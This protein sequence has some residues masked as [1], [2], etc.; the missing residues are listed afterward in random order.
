MPKYILGVDIGGTKCA[1]NLASVNSHVE[2]L[3]RMSFDTKAEL[4]FESVKD[5]LFQGARDILD[6]N[7]IAYNERQMEKNL[8]AI[9][10]SCG[11]PLDCREGLILSPPHLPGWDRI[12]LKKMMTEAFGVPVFVQNDANACALVEWKMG[13]GRGAQNMVFIT[14]GT[15]FGAGIIAEN[16]LI[17]GVRGFA[18]E[19]GHVRLE[20]EGPLVFGKTGT[21]E[22]FCS[23]AGIGHLAM[24]RT[25]RWLAQGHEPAW[26]KDGL[27]QSEL[28]ARVIAQYADAGDEDARSIY[29]EAGEK[30][31]HALAILIDLLNPERIVIGSVFVRSENLLRKAMECV[32]QTE[33]LQ[34]SLEDCQIVPAQTGEQIGDLASICAACYGMGI[35]IAKPYE[36]KK[37]V[38]AHYKR[39]FERYHVLLPLEKKL[40]YAFSLLRGSFIADGKLLVCG[41]GGSAADAEHIV[42]ELMKGF[43]LKRPHHSELIDE[44]LQKALPAIALTQHSSLNT[45]FANDV[46]AE[47][48]FAQQLYGY[49]RMGDVLLCISTSGN[50]QNCVMAA[51]TARALGIQV[52]ALTGKSGGRLAKYADVLLNV[53]AVNTPEVQ[54]LHLPV[55]HTLCAML[56]AEFF[57][58]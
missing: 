40:M 15:G 4:G 44:R 35:D 1:L 43:L 26:V 8:F 42:G 58:E 53:D 19:I 7:A 23:G 32:L 9:G 18:G 36:S 12:P 41:N 20:K 38:I 2:I 51:K 49:G 31:G 52:I 11:G 6:K 17:E 48:V 28:N 29:E 30:L 22:A 33:A 14:M 56:E 34:G 55:Y 57:D 47:L 25:T 3:D 10:V 5:R 24:N 16:R 54:E 45:A 13:A 37:E 39:L 21:V 50:A 27:A 46:A